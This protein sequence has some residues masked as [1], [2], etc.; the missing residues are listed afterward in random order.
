MGRFVLILSSTLALATGCYQPSLVDCVTTCGSSQLCPDGLSCMNGF[1][2][3]E[4]ASG[5]CSGSTP[6]GQM[7][8]CPIAPQNHGTPVC[9]MAMPVSPTPP[10]C[11]VICTP[12][13]TGTAAAMFHFN[14]WL[15]GSIGSAAEE[16]TAKALIGG[17]VWLGLQ[18][19]SGMGGNPAMWAWSSGEAMTYMDWA[20]G[21]PVDMGAGGNCG[22]LTSTGWVSE[23]CSTTHPFMIVA[24]PPP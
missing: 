4:G 16:A 23:P 3:T 14:T 17:P 22:V 18:A 2:R 15:A 24:P 7:G 21:Q 12:F 6:D 11:Q 8:G 1:C 10:T 20:P 9:G 19:P 5:S 13:V